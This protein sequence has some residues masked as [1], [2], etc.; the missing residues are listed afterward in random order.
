MND[1]LQKKYYG[2]FK[3]EKRRE[4]K[5]RKPKE[6]TQL[7]PK[8]RELVER[9][10][11]NE[12][13]GERLSNATWK[14]LSYWRDHGLSGREL[15]SYQRYTKPKKKLSAVLALTT[16]TGERRNSSTPLTAE[17][18]QE[19]LRKPNPNHNPKLP[20]LTLPLRWNSGTLES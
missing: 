5:E 10:K 6:T 4:T 11:Q 7:T 3:S 19:V 16:N 1:G 12:E 13:V 17:Q 8:Q 15:K 14:L 20:C 9:A 2:L 18:E